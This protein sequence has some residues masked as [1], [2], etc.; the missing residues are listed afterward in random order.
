[1]VE[2]LLSNEQKM[3]LKDYFDY[4]N[5]APEEVRLQLGEE[6]D[7]GLNDD[8][9]NL[10]R[11]NSVL[12]SSKKQAVE[13]IGDSTLYELPNG[14]TLIHNDTKK[15]VYDMRF[16]YNYYK[17]LNQKMVSQVRV[18]R[19]IGSPD[20]KNVAE[21]IFFEYLLPA[22]KVVATDTE[23]TSYGKRFWDLRIAEAFYKGYKVYYIDVME[24]RKL[25]SI[26]DHVDFKQNY[27]SAW[28]FGQKYQTR[29]IVISSIE[30]QQHTIEK[31]YNK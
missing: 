18:W 19:D 14:Y 24:P 1:M 23:Q 2:I 31:R 5:E 29:K 30:L 7:W 22:H 8:S 9:V 17:F 25:I 12:K 11:S 15:I 26:K 6:P 4:L 21:K 13:S 16:E 3:K 10:K 27:K 20:S 28:G